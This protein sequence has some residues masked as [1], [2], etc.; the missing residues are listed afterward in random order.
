MQISSERRWAWPYVAWLQAVVAT[1]GS[2]YFSEVMHLPPC[3]LCWYQRLMM[4]PLVFVLLVS[5]LTQDTRLRAYSLPLSVTGLLIAAYHNLLY[6]GVIPEGLTQC[7]AGVSCTARQIEW[8]GFITIPL[9]SLTAFT[10]ITL[11]LL[12]TKPRGT[13]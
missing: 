9:L 2:L 13:A 10:V 5:L 7:A 4:Y 11:S 6:Y 1:T 8:L 3:T 12:L